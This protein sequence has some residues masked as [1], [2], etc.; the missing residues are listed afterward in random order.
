VRWKRNLRQ[1]IETNL[2]FGNPVLIGGMLVKEN[3]AGHSYVID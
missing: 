2:D 1:V 3:L